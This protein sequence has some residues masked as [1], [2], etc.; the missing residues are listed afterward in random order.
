LPVRILNAQPGSPVSISG[1]VN[2]AQNGAVPASGQR[3]LS[4]SYEKI[5]DVL[6]AAGNHHMPTKRRQ[7]PQTRDIPVIVLS[8]HALAGEREEAIAGRL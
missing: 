1:H 5:G 4:A 2:P 7:G 6:V 8:A 3:D